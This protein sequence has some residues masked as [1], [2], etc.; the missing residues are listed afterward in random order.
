MLFQILYE[1]SKAHCVYGFHVGVMGLFLW[2]RFWSRREGAAGMYSHETPGR[3]AKKRIEEIEK[4]KRKKQE[5]KTY[6]LPD[7]R[8]I[9]YGCPGKYVVF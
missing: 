7:G 4:N 2:N 3:L 5:K 1:I 6:P 9:L 8:R